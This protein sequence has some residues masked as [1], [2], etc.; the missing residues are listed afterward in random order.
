MTHPL[1]NSL[2]EHTRS[3]PRAVSVALA[4]LGCAPF[5]HA[6]QTSEEAEQT[7]EEGALGAKEAPPPS[8]GESEL[9]PVP[10]DE[11]ASKS[12]EPSWD[13]GLLLGACGVGEDKVWEVTKF[14]LGGLID[15]MFLRAQEDETGIGAYAELGTAGFRDFRVSGGVTS[16][17]SLVDWFSLSLRAGG[18]G[19]FT[20]EGARPG[21]EGY[22]GL[23]H[24]SVSHSSHYGLSHNLLAGLQYVVPERD[25]PA[26]HAL[27]IGLQVDGVWFTA[28]RGLFR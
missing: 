10:L 11:M 22:V 21:V 28:P 26:S 5:A 23:G 24:R 12:P 20:P 4:V 25:L 7:S 27:W 18:L 16:I 8:E 15:V 17:F 13:T 19:V 2:C 1:G 14:C 6:E 9:P 3:A